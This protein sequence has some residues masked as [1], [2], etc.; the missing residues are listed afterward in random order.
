MTPDQI[1]EIETS[2]DR[3]A[4]VLLDVAAEFYERLFA[5]A[6]EIRELFTEDLA[7]QRA[8]FRSELG[9]IVLSIRDHETFLRQLHD[10]GARHRGYGVRAGHYRSAGPHLIAAL[11]AASGDTWTPATEE[12]W[13]LAYNLVAESMM[14]GASAKAQEPST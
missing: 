14:E 6:P 10:L 13:R 12:A 2:L 11:A 3:L 1:A 9:M 8:V 4:P 5:H 7:K